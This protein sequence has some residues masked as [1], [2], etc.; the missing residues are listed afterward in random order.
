MTDMNPF[1]VDVSSHHNDNLSL[2]VEYVWQH[3][4]GR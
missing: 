3:N 4:I 1:N 2:L